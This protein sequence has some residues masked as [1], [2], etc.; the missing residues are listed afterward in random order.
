MRRR[1]PRFIALPLALLLAAPAFAAEVV[2]SARDCA[3]LVRHRP[4][5]GVAY[6]PGVDVHGRSVVG[7]DLNGGYAHIKP[8]AELSF[9]IK[10]PL[11]NFLGGPAADAQAATAAV[12]AA[13]S[14][15]TAAGAADAAATSAEAAAAAPPANTASAAAAASAR[16]NA[17][18]ATAAVSAA[19]KSAAAS[20]AA[21]AA[22][23][24]AAADPG[25]APLAAAAAAANTTAGAATAASTATAKE[26]RRAART[27]QYVGEAVIGRVTV[28]GHEVYYNGRLLGDPHR[29]AIAAA[30]S[31][32]LES[33]R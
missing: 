24:A 16:V 4:A 21:A 10:V 32:R 8:P 6:R 15:A 30:C 20:L 11:R 23:Q 2:V 31:A 5:P 33:K 22:L 12:A 17:D 27:G 13:D 28:R 29:A 3:D 9:D 7:A 18:A 25:N 19:D 26:Y 14:A 1:A